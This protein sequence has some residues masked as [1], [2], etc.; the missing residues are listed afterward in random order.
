MVG[1]LQ[2]MTEGCEF[3]SYSSGASGR[4]FGVQ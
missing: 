1:Y 2:N 3:D 4:L